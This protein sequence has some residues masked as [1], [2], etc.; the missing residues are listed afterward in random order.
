MTMKNAHC[1]W[2][3]TCALV[4]AG[5]GMTASRVTAQ[6]TA[7]T[8]IVDN[9]L[10]EVVVEGAAGSKGTKPKQGTST[11]L[12]DVDEK[13]APAASTQAAPGESGAAPSSSSKAGAAQSASSAGLGGGGIPLTGGG[14]ITGTSTSIITREQIA[15][16]PQ[17]TLPDIIAREAGVQSTS[18][19]G[20]ANG[21]GTTVDLRGFGATASS[22]TL[23]LIDGRRLNDWDLAGFDLSTIAKDSIERVEITRGNSGAVLYGD[24]AVGGV[25]NI[26]TRGGAGLP[27]SARVEGGLGSFDTWQGSA[28]ASASSGPFSGFVN[29]TA[30]QSDGYRDNNDLK[31]SAIVGDFRWAFNGG[32][33]YLNLGADQQDLGL[34]GPRRVTAGGINQV[35]D[36]PRGTDT[37]LDYADEQSV[38][39]TLGL[40]YMLAPNVEFI[41]DGGVRRKDQQAGFFA[42]F[43]ESYVETDLTTSSITPRLNIT[44]PVLGLPSRILTGVDFYDT[45]YASDRS[46]FKGLDPIHMYE[47]RQKS[48]AGY[49]QQTLSV[50]PTTDVSA[51][52]RL[53]WNG[54]TASDVFDQNAPGGSSCFPSVPCSPNGGQAPALDDDETNYAWHLGVEHRVLPGVALFG[55]MARSFRVPNIDERIASGPFFTPAFDLATQTSHDWEIGTRLSYGTVSFQTSYYEMDL[56]NELQF[57]PVNFVNKNLDPTRRQGVETIAIW[58]MLPNLRLNGN[59]TYINAEFRDGPNA[60]NEVPLVSPWTGSL[61][62]S[63]DVV[64]KLLTFD[65]NVRYVGERRMDNDQVNLQPLIDAY[66]TVDVRLGGQVDQFFWSAAVSNLF[67]VDY[68]DYAVASAFTIGTYNAYPLP[69]RT[70]MVKAGAKW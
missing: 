51:G 15:R 64:D 37:P 25:I 28:S 50:S 10:P 5:A 33:V 45:D 20:G 16:S 53:Q 36:D 38:R 63:W 12:Y 69:G 58:Q 7:K 29:A 67:D 56:T 59:V 49:A 14:G 1:A 40:T 55:R 22:N 17:D 46:Q 68:F 65:A 27:N 43:A 39:S 32:S 3:M 8:T 21:A 31:Q 4:S 48:V 30:I 18:L 52:G 34:P 19:Y 61:G 11:R 47:A 9:E 6:E 66:T 44:Q 60:G 54:T 35:R 42:P 62:L 13:P 26:V 70:F 24:G 57:D 41:I 2:M 23:V